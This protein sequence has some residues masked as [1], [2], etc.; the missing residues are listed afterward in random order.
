MSVVGRLLLSWLRFK[1]SRRTGGGTAALE[2][3]A[4]D[5]STEGQNDGAVFSWGDKPALEPTGRAGLCSEKGCAQTVAD[6][7]LPLY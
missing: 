6:V 2:L 1:G 4:W 7:L 3:W 5:V